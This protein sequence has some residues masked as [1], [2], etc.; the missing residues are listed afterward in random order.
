MTRRGTELLLLFI[1]CVIVMIMFG[2]LVASGVNEV[3]FGY[4]AIPVG[5]IISF[6]VAHVAVRKLAPAADPVILPI[7]LV[8]TGIGLTFITRLNPDLALRQVV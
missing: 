6:L 8:L 5:I 1:A 7:V 4:I 2:I 3:N